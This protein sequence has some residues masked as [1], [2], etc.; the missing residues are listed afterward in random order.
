MGSGDW[1]GVLRNTR[2]HFTNRTIFF[3]IA[4]Q[5]LELSQIGAETLS[6]Y[7]C[8][9]ESL[10]D[11]LN[12]VHIRAGFSWHGQLPNAYVFEDSPCFLLVKVLVKFKDQ[13]DFNP[14]LSSFLWTSGGLDTQK[15]PTGWVQ[16]TLICGVEIWH[17]PLLSWKPAFTYKV[18]SL[19]TMMGPSRRLRSQEGYLSPP[20][21]LLPGSFFMIT[22]PWGQC[23]DKLIFTEV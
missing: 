23:R 14:Y 7:G 12:Y 1:T 8:Y 16:N 4:S 22:D 15:V 9:S 5:P 21:T 17:L 18:L 10:L 3:F 20:P 13:G 19:E 6:G 2:E 11:L